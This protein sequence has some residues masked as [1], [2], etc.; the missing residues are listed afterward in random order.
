[1][2][3]GGSVGG[4][5]GGGSEGGGIG[6]AAGE[7]KGRVTGQDEVECEGVKGEL[8]AEARDGGVPA[9]FDFLTHTAAIR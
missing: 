5:A 7:S 9:L 3:Y 2:G 1:M 6:R 8:Y 4:H